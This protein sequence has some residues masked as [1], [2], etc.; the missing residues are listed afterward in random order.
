LLRVANEPFTALEI[1][2]SQVDVVRRYGS[3]VHFGDA[4]KLDLLRAAGA[5]HA[6]LFVL[7]IDD[8]EAS[9]RTAETV[10]R[11]FPNLTIVARARNRRHQYKLMDLGIRNIFRE[12]FLSS[13]AISKQVLVNLGNNEDDVE[14]M[15]D[16][17]QQH[18]RKLIVE[19]HAVQHD[20]SRLI[21]SARETARE[22]E[23]LLKHDL[24]Q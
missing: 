17:F 13:I 6:E 11:H 24:D 5:E 21:Q 3:K 19:Q 10:S 14:H 18:D 23:S 1:D 16:L 7:A 22:L 20:E 9:V 2:S 8:I 4:S 12:T 15:A